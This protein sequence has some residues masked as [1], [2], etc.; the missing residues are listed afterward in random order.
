M[1]SVFQH[2]KHF[3]PSGCK[4]IRALSKLFPYYG[5][6]RKKRPVVTVVPCCRGGRWLRGLVRGPDPASGV[7]VTVEGPTHADCVWGLR[8]GESEAMN[9]LFGSH[10][11]GW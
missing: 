6:C 4:M 3:S 10:G 11:W 9:P 7:L 1:S 8:E 2:L 5:A